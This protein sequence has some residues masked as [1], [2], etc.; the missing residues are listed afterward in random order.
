MNAKLATKV[1]QNVHLKPKPKKLY[2]LTSNKNVK[3]D[4]ITNDITLENGLERHRVKTKCRSILPKEFKETIWNNFL[5]LKEQSTIVSP[6]VSSSFAKD[7]TN[8]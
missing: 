7:I 1:F 8:W 5:G 6:T 4:C 3:H 2:E